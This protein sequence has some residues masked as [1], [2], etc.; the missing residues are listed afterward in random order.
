MASTIGLNPMTTTNAAGSF[1]VKSDGMIQGMAFDDPATRYALASGT[2]ATT[3]ILPMW[4]G[5]AVSELI[6]GTSSAPMGGNIV[7]PT[8]QAGITGFS[9]FNQ[10]HNG[11][12]TPQSPVPVALSGMSVSFYRLGSGARV[13]VAVSSAIASLAGTGPLVNVP[14]QFIWNFATAALDIFSTIA[15]TVATTAIT[16]TAATT[17]APGYATATTA[18]AHGLAAGA[19]VNITGAVPTAYNGLVQVLSVPTSTTFTYAPVSVPGVTPATTQGSVAAATAASVALPVM[20]LEVQSGNS[21]TVSYSSG[22][23]TW[24]NSGACGLILL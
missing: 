7:R 15:S 8:A 20:L 16:Y 22:N 2:L 14:N 11:V 23:A 19:Y 9:V 1:Y 17:S 18:S 21:K 24:N 3:E 4:G 6:P 10:A 12:T 5:L 13:P